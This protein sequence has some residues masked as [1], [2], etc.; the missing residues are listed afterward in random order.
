MKVIS[1][2]LFFLNL[3]LFVVFSAW[4]ITRYYLYPEDWTELMDHPTLS[5]FWGCF[6]MSFTT[7]LNVA[8]N[9]IYGYFSFGGKGFLYSIWVLWWIDVAVSSAYCWGMMHH[10]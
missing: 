10:M 5:L 7:I 3:L 2:I 6:P 8:I 1:L 9:V 4:A